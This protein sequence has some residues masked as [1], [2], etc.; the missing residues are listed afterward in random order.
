MLELLGLVALVAAIG[1]VVC[2]LAVVGL[3]L[4]LLLKIAL[5]PISL[6]WALLKALLV[7]LAALACLAILGPLTLGLALVILIPVLIIAGI[8]WAAMA[9]AGAV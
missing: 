6:A 7:G 8:V 4:K 3:A 5:I 9:V 1:V 2:V